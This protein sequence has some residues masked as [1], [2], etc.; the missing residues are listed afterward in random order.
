MS[1]TETIQKDMLTSGKKGNSAESDILK[2]VLSSLKNE[3]IAKSDGTDL[4]E[5]EEVEIVFSEAK[6]I[7]DSIEQF[8]KAGREDL[9]EREKEQLAVIERYL[10]EQAEDED[11]RKAVKEAIEETGASNPSHMGMVM[12]ASMKKLWGKADG[13][14]VSEVV[15]EMLS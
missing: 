11:I 8:E 1:L 2:V 12:G 6:K 10:P 3:K 15:K 14:V 5:E 13:K 9:A 4:T 7:K